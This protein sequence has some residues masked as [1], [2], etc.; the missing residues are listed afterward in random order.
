M[1]VCDSTWKR[2]R[3]RGRQVSYDDE[4]EEGPEEEEEEEGLGG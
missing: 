3:I 1:A 2:R 4:V